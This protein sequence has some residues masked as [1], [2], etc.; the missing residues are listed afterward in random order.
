MGNIHKPFC[1][2]LSWIKTKRLS[3]NR[4]YDSVYLYRY[5][6]GILPP[7]MLDH[8]QHLLLYKVTRSNVLLVSGAH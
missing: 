5:Q 7:L 3:L 8:I 2:Q 4:L 6:M 1:N